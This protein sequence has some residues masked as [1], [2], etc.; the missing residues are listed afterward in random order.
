MDVRKWLR[1]WGPIVAPGCIWG[2]SYLFIAEGLTAM[3]PAG[4]TFVRTSI[5]FA[6][7]SFIPGVR[8]PVVRQDRRRVPLLGLIWL[9]APMSMFPFA[10]QHVS[11]ALTG[12]LNAA[13]PL[14]VAVVAA[15]QSRS[16]PSRAVRMALGVGLGGAALIAAPSLGNGR[17]EVWGVG[18]VVGAL[19]FYGFAINLARPLQQR[20][21]ALPVIW[22][23]VGIAALLTAPTGLPAV[24]D[25]TWTTSALL[26]MVAL[27]ALG[28]GVANVLVATAAGNSTVTR[29][30]AMAFIIPAVSLSLGVVIRHEHVSL[31]SVAGGAVCLGG[32]W[33]LGRAASTVPQAGHESSAT[34]ALTRSTISERS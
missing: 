33:L 24:I 31:I 8:R 10:E 17:S 5:G 21:G 22:R 12:L 13:T 9:A 3:R 15:A 23:A 18:L 34:N 30:A 20:N 2:A 14:F 19:C 32:A 11:S 27:G 6:V 1:D 4:I 7:L 16:L 26:S 28:T 25:A 29:A